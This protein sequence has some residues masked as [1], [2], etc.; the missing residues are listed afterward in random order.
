MSRPLCAV[1]IGMLAL[2]LNGSVGQAQS[3][4]QPVRGW[5]VGVAPVLATVG[6]GPQA[7]FEDIGETGTVR[8]GAGIAA[9]I[10]RRVGRAPLALHLGWSTHGHSPFG[11]EL[12]VTGRTQFV[13]GALV[14]SSRPVLG[15]RLTGELGGGLLYG[16]STTTIGL[17]GTQIGLRG[18]DA[19]IILTEV[20]PLGTLAA[21]YQLHRTDR[22]QIAV[23]AAV[24]FA[25]TV[26]EGT[27]LFP[28]S[29]QITR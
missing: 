24:E 11:S 23:R 9:V 4:E 17:T 6:A 20:A 14:A 7:S 25:P 2:G 26:G 19:Q 12:S 22:R 13:R 18:A 28:I 15:D 8:G 3:S 16:R 27:L 1:A 29:L 21:V 5:R 10:A